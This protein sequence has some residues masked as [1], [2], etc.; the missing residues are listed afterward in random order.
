MSK[1][2]Y[3]DYDK[4][5][6][7]D[8]YINSFNNKNNVVKYINGYNNAVEESKQI[9]YTDYVG[10][11]M[12][13]ITTIINA[14]SY[15]L[16]AFVSVSLVVSCIMIGII[17]NIS[18]VE[19]TKEIGILRAIGASKQNISQVFNA[20]TFIIG[21]A[22]GIIGIVV[23][24]LL[25]VPINSLIHMVLPEIHIRA[26]IPM[27][28]IIVL[29]VISIIITIIGGLYPAKKASNMDPVKALRSE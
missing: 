24:A 29:V 16:M 10:L 28:A 12:S 2:G 11:M 22:S 6:S 26:Q 8:I 14:I 5:A 25:T 15:V 7:I 3:V 13:S 9:V 19:R 27:G 23:A 4:P 18:V 20:E 17:T 21:L 1:F